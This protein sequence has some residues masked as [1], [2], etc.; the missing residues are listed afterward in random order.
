M[1]IYESNVSDTLQH[2]LDE[3]ILI[4]IDLLVWKISMFK[5]RTKPYK[6]FYTH[7]RYMYKFTKIYGFHKFIETY[8]QQEM[9]QPGKLREMHLMRQTSMSLEFKVKGAQISWT[10]DLPIN[11][12]QFNLQVLQSEKY[13]HCEKSI[14]DSLNVRYKKTIRDKLGFMKLNQRLWSLEGFCL[15]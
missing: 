7:Y 5:T 8:L 4:N 1:Y 13:H 14:A 9:P 10:I 11:T 15:K 2:E 3:L 12:E 6:I